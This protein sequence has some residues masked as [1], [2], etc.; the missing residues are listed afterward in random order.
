MYREWCQQESRIGRSSILIPSQK[1][2]LAATHDQKCLLADLGIQ[3]EDWETP[4]ELRTEEGHFDKAG[5][6]PNVRSVTSDV[7]AVGLKNTCNP[8]NWAPALLVHSP[9]TSPIHQR[10]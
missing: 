8:G 7:Q 6:D 5:P 2:D 1:Q 9:A 4:V 3:V 10:T